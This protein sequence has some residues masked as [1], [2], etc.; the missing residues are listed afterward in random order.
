MAIYRHYCSFTS[1]SLQHCFLLAIQS[2]SDTSVPFWT[3]RSQDM[4]QDSKSTS[5]GV[6]C[7]LGKANFRVN[8]L[9]VSE[10]HSHSGSN[11]VRSG[12]NLLLQ[13]SAQFDLFWLCESGCAYHGITDFVTNT[14]MK[15]QHVAVSENSVHNYC[16]PRTVIWTWRFVL[17]RQT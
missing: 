13:W 4:L 12:T 8:S 17:S 5:G 10:N 3:H 7:I 2:K 1:S 6:L 16:V 15:V 9:D 14:L 11:H